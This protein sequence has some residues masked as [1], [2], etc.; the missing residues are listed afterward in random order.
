MK[1]RG[2]SVATPERGTARAD[3]GHRAWHSKDEGLHYSDPRKENIVK[4]M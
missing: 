2:Q 1:Q 3:L 4:T